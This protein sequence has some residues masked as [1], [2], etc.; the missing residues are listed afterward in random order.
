[1]NAMMNQAVA[2]AIPEELEFTDWVALG[3][4][5]FTRH[6]QTEWM[7]AD[8]L[9]VGTERFPDEAQ[10]ALFLDEIGVD[11][12]R[13]LADAKVA[14]LIPPAWRSDAVSFDVC[15]QIARVEDEATRQRL[16]KRAVDEHW[17][18]REAHH[19]IVEHKTEEGSLFED[20]DS[21]TR[22]AVHGIR[23]WNRAP[24]ESREYFFALAEISA[25]TGFNAIDEDQAL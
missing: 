22:I 19:H 4:E 12:K 3:R 7:L 1:M 23:W 11:T 21:V 24:R 10:M 17:N 14:A 5:L 18:E 15:K 6:R 13:A 16:L 2:L 9:R 8:W 20:E 25:A